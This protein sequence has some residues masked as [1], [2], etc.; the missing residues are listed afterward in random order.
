VQILKNGNPTAVGRSEWFTGT[1]YVAGWPT[2]SSAVTI[3]R[4]VFEENGV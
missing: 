4:R 2:A 3:A 1:V